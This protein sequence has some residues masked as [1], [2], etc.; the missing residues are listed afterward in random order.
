MTW[1]TTGVVLG[2]TAA[3][4]LASAC[5]S[6]SRAVYL[7]EKNDSSGSFGNSD[8]GADGATAA[9]DASASHLMCATSECPAGT[10]TCET[11]SSRCDVDLMGDRNNCGA[12]GAACP[13][14]S[15]YVQMTPGP[16]LE[17]TFFCAS[18]KCEMA[19]SH[20]HADCDGVPD[21]GCEVD[22]TMTDN[23]GACGVKCADNTPCTE[24]KCGCKDGFTNCNG[25][26][27]DIQTYTNNCGECGHLCEDTL[28]LPWEFHRPMQCIKGV[29]NNA[30]E[31]GYGDCDSD[32]ETNGCEQSL[33]DDANCG[34]CGNV[35]QNGTHCSLLDDAWQCGCPS[36]MR[37]CP[38]WDGPHCYD[39]LTDPNNC[40]GC[41]VTCQSGTSDNVFISTSAAV[42]RGGVCDLLCKSGQADCNGFSGDGCEIDLQTDPNHCGSCDHACDLSIG[43]PCV[44]GECVVTE[45]GEGQVP[46]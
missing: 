7:G 19:C 16:F 1:K 27:V 18:G 34:A 35:C 45:C 42:C 8:A 22:L 12:C 30:C 23:C 40:G 31:G 46:R 17:V 43:Q 26:C 36:G 11:S 2:I 10:A 21:N 9:D 44:K 6:E 13:K 38:F 3:T 15:V 25:E 37:G 24:G 39:I 4:A 14:D 33:K 20:D 28:Q 41:G 29:C 5:S 32:L